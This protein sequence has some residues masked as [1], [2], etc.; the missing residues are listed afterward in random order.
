M[1]MMTF[2]AGLAIAAGPALA[3]P[4]TDTHDSAKAVGD[5][6][7]RS[8]DVDLDGMISRRELIDFGDQVF[9]SVDQ[10]GDGMIV[11]EEL[12]TWQFGLADLAE[13]RGRDQAYLTSM[14]IVFDVMDRN[15]DQTVSSSEYERATL[16]S[17]DYANVN[18]DDLLTREEYLQG[19]IFNI[20]MRNAFQS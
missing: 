20:A 5:M 17:A 15:N 3:A 14:A 12:Q 9:V 1:K 7:A 19:Y 13:F 18:G 11:L 16:V 4:L 8:I 10:D 6:F 2:L